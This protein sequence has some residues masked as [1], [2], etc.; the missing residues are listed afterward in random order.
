MQFLVIAYDFTD[1]AALTRRL[2]IRA[3]HIAM[4]DKLIITG[5]QIMAVALLDDAGKMNGSAMICEYQTRAE[6]DA[7]LQVEPYVV[8]KVWDQIDILPCKVGPSF[9]H[10]LAKH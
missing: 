8:G 6:L 9:V 4:S 2:A 5:N 3:D 7:W 10:L 1:P